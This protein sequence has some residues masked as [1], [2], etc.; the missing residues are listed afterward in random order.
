MQAKERQLNMAEEIIKPKAKA[1]DFI[2]ALG[3][4]KG[5]I[6]RVR[7]YKNTVSGLSFGNITLKKGDIVVNGRHVSEYFSTPSAKSILE[8]PFNITN[9]LNKYTL[10]IR[11]SGGG[12]S[13]QL[14]A[15]VLAVSRALTIVDP[16]NRTLLKKKGLLERDARVR[17]RRNVG[18]GGKSRRKKQS[19]KR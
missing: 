10:T 18:M 14:G 15:V 11:V 16:Q 19:P 2:F 6:A 12:M 5:A 1:K 4:R 7:L 17:Q 3:R 13:G 8:V 9:T